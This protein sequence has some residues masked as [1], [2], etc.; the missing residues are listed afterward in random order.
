MRPVAALSAVTIAMVTAFGVSGCGSDEPPPPPVSER[1]QST[2]PPSP[3]TAPLPPPEQL[4][5]VLSQLADTSIPPERKLSLVQYATP[6]DQDTLANFGQALSDG[7]FRDLAVE[8][9]DLAWASTPGN[10]DATVR[11]IP[12]GDAARA[13][14]FPMEFS[15]LRD[16]W[17]LT[18]QTADQLLVLGSTPPPTPP[19]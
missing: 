16:G 8:A 9:T 3:A 5:A 10:V 13:F 2:T 18:R 15:P 4:A 7:G 11:L 1:A 17:Q 12:A 14:T 6:E 19:G